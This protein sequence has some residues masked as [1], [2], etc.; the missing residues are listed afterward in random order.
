MPIPP[1]VLSM[2][3]C[4]AVHRDAE[5]GKYYLIGSFAS[6][7]FDRFPAAL[8]TVHLFLSMIE[9]NGS[10]GL[11]ARIVDVTREDALVF[12]TGGRLEG[13]DPLSVFDFYFPLSGVEFTQPGVYRLQLLADGD[14][15]AE[16]GLLIRRRDSGPDDE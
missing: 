13:A 15:I 7:Q 9:V 2:L 1:I 8:P 14:V 5:T 12:E 4:D 16:R 10:Y 11:S 3:L 6:R